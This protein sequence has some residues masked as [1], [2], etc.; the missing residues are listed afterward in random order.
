MPSAP[1]EAG[2]TLERAS[3][4]LLLSFSLFHVFFVFVFFFNVSS[5]VYAALLQTR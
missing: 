5:G 2:L 3:L 4:V 1:A